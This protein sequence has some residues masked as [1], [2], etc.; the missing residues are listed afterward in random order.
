MP[1]IV[2]QALQLPLEMQFSNQ[3]IRET[4]QPTPMQRLFLESQHARDIR[5][6]LQL[7][8]D[9]LNPLQF[10]QREAYLKARIEL[11]HELLNL[12]MYYP[13]QQPQESNNV[14]L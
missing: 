9:P 8:Y 4:C 11:I 6:R 3:E 2:P 1:E 13:D 7:E 5:Q 14:S 12:E 10:V